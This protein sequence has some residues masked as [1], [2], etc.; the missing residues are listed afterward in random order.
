MP[1]ANVNLCRK[2]LRLLIF[3]KGFTNLK[4]SKSGF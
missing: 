4:T 2:E 1:D 3:N